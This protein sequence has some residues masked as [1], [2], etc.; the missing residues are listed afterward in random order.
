MRCEGATIVIE[1]GVGEVGIKIWRTRDIIV[2]TK[3][4]VRCENGGFGGIDG[5]IAASRAKRERYR[6]VD[7]GWRDCG[8]G[9]EE[10]G[11]ASEVRQRPS[12]AAK[13]SCD[14][15]QHRGHPLW[16]VAEVAGVDSLAN[17]VPVSRH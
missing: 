7:A 11:V 3:V 14:V 4:C 17:F 13:V 6:G 10:T 15:E 12:T 2:L 1:L 16:A 5:C 9:D 8:Q